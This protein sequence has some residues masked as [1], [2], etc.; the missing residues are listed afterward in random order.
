MLKPNIVILS[1]CVNCKISLL[2][3]IDTPPFNSFNEVI[4]SCP[5]FTS[6]DKKKL[7]CLLF[8]D[9]I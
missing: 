2:P 3:E 8:E 5:T 4:I 1:N 6:L 9:D 7:L